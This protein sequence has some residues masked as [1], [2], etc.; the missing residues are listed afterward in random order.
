MKTITQQNRKRKKHRGS[1]NE[2]VLQRTFLFACILLL[3]TGMGHGA[4]A[5]SDFTPSLWNP[6]LK[7]TQGKQLASG[8]L[9]ILKVLP[10]FSFKRIWLAWKCFLK[11]KNKKLSFQG[12]YSIFC[13]H[14]H[15]AV[16]GIHACHANNSNDDNRIN[17]SNS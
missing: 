17:N 2:S 4:S 14:L 11:N 13:K 1:I 16:D 10:F 5:F 7:S 15:C 3:H 12:N 8:L 6:Q 9:L